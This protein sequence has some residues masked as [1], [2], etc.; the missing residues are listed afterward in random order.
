MQPENGKFVVKGRNEV[1]VFEIVSGE[2]VT[3]AEIIS[4]IV[5]LT[6]AIVKI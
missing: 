4:D 2:Y 5:Q 1:T 6:S 3:F